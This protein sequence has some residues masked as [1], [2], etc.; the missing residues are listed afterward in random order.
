MASAVSFDTLRVLKE[1]IA[2]LA[3]WCII[4][5]SWKPSVDG[6]RAKAVRRLKRRRLALVCETINVRQAIAH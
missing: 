2:G 6:D 5:K 3:L 4:V 1:R